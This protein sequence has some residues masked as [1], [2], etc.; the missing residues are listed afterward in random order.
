MTVG[1]VAWWG[2]RIVCYG[3]L[4]FVLA[5]TISLIV[6]FLLNLSAQSGGTVT[7]TDPFYRSIYEFGF[8]IV[9]MS[10]FTGA[11]VLL[12]FAGLVFLIKDI[13]WRRRK[14]ETRRPNRS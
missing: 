5:G 9:L 6:P 12:A 10:V 7:C 14:L 3:G 13:F 4:V 1:R 2:V 8:S 11:P